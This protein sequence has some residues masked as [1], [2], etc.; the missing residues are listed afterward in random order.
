MI[1]NDIKNILISKEQI[2]GKVKLLGEEISRDYKDRELLLVC[3]LKG[4]LMFMADLMKYINT[5]VEIDFMGVSSYGNSI[6]SSGQVRIMKD[7]D[8]SV[9]GK[10]ILIVEDIIDTGIT[11]NYICNYIKGLK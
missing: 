5:Y 10:D 7:L 9:E 11:L 4:S 6:I 8:M 3:I 2:Q 1:N